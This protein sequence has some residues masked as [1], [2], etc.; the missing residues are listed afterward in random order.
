MKDFKELDKRPVSEV[1]QSILASW[2]GVMNIYKK[3]NELRNSAKTFV[4]YDG[5][6][7]ANGFPGLHHMLAKFLK[8]SI[9][10]YH[11][12]KGE[13]V[14]RKVGW[15]THGLPVEL[16][17]EKDLGFTGK[18][19]IEKYGIQEFNQKCKES[20]WKNK[21]AFTDLTEKMG[22]FIDIENPYVTYDND[23]IETEW[24]ILK[25]F[26]KSGLFYEGHKILP[27]CPRCGTGL[28]SHEVAQGYK[29]ITVETVIVP[30]KKK[31]ED[32]Y[33]LV[34]TTTPWTLIS[35]VALCVNPEFTYV[36]VKS[37]DYQFILAESLASK[38]LGETF[39]ILET[40]KG[41]DLEYMEYEQL[42]PELSV[43][44]KAFY[45]TCDSYVTA[46][47][48]TG[49]VHIAPSFGEDDASVGKKYDL[50][51][52]NPVGEDGHYTEGP[53]KGM[54]IFDADKEVIKYLKEND[55]LFKKQKMVHN[56][57]HCWRCDSPLVYYSKPS[58]YLKVT[59][60]KDQIVEANKNVNWFPKYVGE[61]RF[62]NWLLNMNDWAISRSRYWGTPLPYWTCPCGHAEMIG[63]RKELVEKA[64]EKIDETI[65][66]HRP[67]VDDVHLKCPVCGG[68]M[69]RTKDVI[70]CWFD[71]G[72]MPFAQYHYPFENV[73][74]FEN[75]FPA[76]FIC[77]GIDQ[78][79]GWFYTLIIIS[80]FL[81]GVAPY[82][83]VLVNDLIQDALG[84]KMSK[85]KGNI[86]EPF[87]TMREYGAD[88]VRFYLPYVSPVW[89]PLR[90]DMNG[91]KEVHSKFFNP[92]KNTYTFFQMYANTD[93]ID[94]DTCDVPYERREEI[95]K[96]LLSKY[97][98]L[99][100]YVTNAYEEYDLNKVVRAVTE[101]VS[102]DLSNWYIRRNRKRFW[103]SALDD[104]KKAVYK[105]TY[106]VLE[107]LCRMMA[108]IIPFT[109]EEIYT[110]LTGEESVHLSDFP[111]VNASL[112][113]EEIEARM[114]LV[115]DLISIGRMVREEAKI[116]VRQPL[117]EALIDGKNEMLIG[118]LVPLISEELNV[119]SVLFVS[120]LNQYMNFTVKPNFKV[121][122][123]MF[124]SKI[125]EFQAK[126]EALSEEEIHK[127]NNDETI[128]MD[129]GGETIEIKKEFVD[130]RINAKDGF[131]VG[132]EN[133][134]FI[135]LNTL[136]TTDLVLEGIAREFVSKVQNMRKTNDYNVT[137]RIHIYVS[138]DEDFKKSL[139]LFDDYIKKETL[140]ISILPKEGMKE[141]Y[142]LNGHE[143]FIEV[144]KVKN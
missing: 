58:Y 17:V 20:V 68:V 129:L 7:T 86:V 137:D 51:F 73:D 49:I 132:M 29:E 89:T 114:D 141:S 55:K 93:G 53:W 30:M 28:A 78:T 32:V 33:F 76:D 39:E 109:T 133:N 118:D 54:L 125:K 107:G 16:G 110:K 61:K 120:E 71:S 69:T 27:Y 83:N 142:D 25:E 36:K 108:P 115:R 98:K 126:L 4:F 50:P 2:G 138:G 67:F 84:K 99:L 38:V 26:F 11:V 9:C 117:S 124:G 43:S 44:K 3:Q 19:D 57:P 143:V 46:S 88:V 94:I 23:Y 14:I 90:F 10:K 136:L 92:L 47:D 122:G 135:I 112:I 119:K 140:A 106:E 1:E 18:G 144:E 22:Q 103:A 131:N 116:K 139:E 59:E 111:K 48:G 15:D 127:L 70:D 123:K 75:Q 91:L 104:S 37:G 65:D 6:A 97:N 128:S 56:Y 52:L 101:F 79:R 121:V 42:I 134:H 81:K 113:H 63:S 74:I 8:D 95:D 85:S 60:I 34:W 41:S 100:E 72:A 5:P 62:G 35:N 31:D 45:V 64:I 96:W 102:E 87:T 24:Y 66:L 12:M 77:E 82:K 105:T 13:K 21:E 130:I 40:Y 80:V